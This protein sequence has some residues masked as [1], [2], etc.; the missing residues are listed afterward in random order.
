MARTRNEMLAA[1]IAETGWSQPKVAAAVLRVAQEAG[2]AELY[3]I[4]RSHVS[5]WVLGTRPSG[6]APHI[7]CETL[8]RKLG[9]PITLV[10]IGLEPEPGPRAASDWS[11]DTLTMLAE[12]GRDDLDMLQ[13]RQMLASTAYSVAGLALPGPAWWEETRAAARQR[14]A[15][16]PRTVTEAD[17]DDIRQTTAFFS[18][19]DQQRG[20]AAGRSALVAHL[21]FEAAPLLNSH[22]P[23]DQVG[24]NLHSALAE[25]TY[26]AGWMAFDASEH[27]AAQRYLT[28]GV[29]L[30]AEA[31]DGPLAGH[32]LRAMAHQAVD[33]GHSRQARDLADASMESTRYGRASWREK[34]LLGIVHARTLAAS[35]DRPGTLAA[36]SRAERDLGRD[37]GDAPGRV[38]FFGEASLAHETA[39]ALRDLGNPRDA[40]IHFQRSV[41]TRRRQLYARTHSV[42]LGYL[43]AVQIRQGRLD[44]ACHTWTQALDAMTGVHSGRARDVIVRM[45]R[46]LSPVRRRGGRQVTELDQRAQEMLRSIG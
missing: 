23:D 42:T 41:A 34:A 1:R 24:R 25:M 37:T 38:S 3:G 2:V 44:E 9:R 46:D 35:G 30:A 22:F 27:R 11:V 33:L 15:S 14:P 36:I 21:R 43:G 6:Q 20:G 26:L 19:R 13:R 31:G 29:R 5:M 7:L 28:L 40:E 8:T 12:L 17:I 45:Q 18:N 39:C 10:D 4:S 16:S 32:I